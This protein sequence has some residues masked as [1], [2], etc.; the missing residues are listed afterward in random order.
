[1]LDLLDYNPVSSQ[2]EVRVYEGRKT[3]IRDTT[4]FW[5]LTNDTID[6]PIIS[7]LNFITVRWFVANSSSGRLTL[8]VRSS[9]F[10][11]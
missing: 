7:Q 5:S 1:M 10:N 11:K 3:S 9:K 8:F 2:E 6:F 4:S